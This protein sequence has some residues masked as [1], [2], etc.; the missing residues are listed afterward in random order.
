MTAIRSVA[1][2]V[3]LIVLLVGVP[4][5]VVG[6][7]DWAEVRLL[8]HD[9]SI[10]LLQDNG[11]VI[12]AILT[13]LG[14][15]FWVFLA[16]GIFLEVQDAIRVR[17]HG[18]TDKP[19]RG[20]LEWT[21]V[22]VRPL[23]S[24]AF[25]LAV[26][27]GG[28]H[29][30]AQEPTEPVPVMEPAWVGESTTSSQAEVAPRTTLADLDDGFYVVEPGD[31]LWSIAEKVYSNGQEWSRIAH[32]NEDLVEGTG[33]L[34]HVGWKLKIPPLSATDTV[35]PG[36]AVVVGPGDSLWSIADRNLGDGN[37]WPDIVR[38]N[39]GLV[40]DADLIQPGWE[41]TLPVEQPGPDD[42]G[43]TSAVSQGNDEGTTAL[44][45]V[46]AVPQKALGT[47]N[48]HSTRGHPAS[49]AST[50][51]GV[52]GVPDVAPGP[53]QEPTGDELTPPAADI[54]PQ[55]E[56]TPTDHSPQ[57]DSTNPSARPSP[58]DPSA[59]PSPTDSAAPTT[60]AAASAAPGSPESSSA[61][62]PSEPVSASP[63]SPSPDAGPSP[64][65]NSDHHTQQSSTIATIGMSTVLAGG[66]VLLVGRRRLTQLRA[67][68]L[69]RRILL[70]GQEGT[71]LETAMGIAGSRTIAEKPLVSAS[72]ECEETPPDPAA[73]AIAMNL[74]W[75]SETGITICLG[76]DQ[77]A[78]PVRAEVSGP[79]P[80]IVRAP[81]PDGLVPVMR[82]IAMSLA[83]DEFSAGRDLHVVDS[84]DLFDTF[85]DLNRHITYDQG[86]D[87]LQSMIADRRRFIGD[88]DWRRLS[89]D[90]NGAEAWRPAIFFF[91]EPVSDPQFDELSDCLKGRDIGVAVLISRNS[92]NPLDSRNL[93]SGHLDLDS[94]D[95]GIL[96]P[97]N[98]SVHPF[99]L[100]PSEPLTDLLRTSSSEDTTPAWWSVRGNTQSPPPQ[101]VSPTYSD[102]RGLDMISIAPSQTDAEAITFSHPVLK[103]LGPVCLE[104]TQGAAPIRAERSCMEYC[105][106][107]LEHPGTTATAMAQGLLVAEGTRR[108]NMSRL[109]G[110]LG[111]DTKGN[112]YLPE[113]YSGRIWLDTAV[114]SDWHRLRVLI[115]GGIESVGTDKLIQALRL[116]RGAPL[117]DV[118]PGQWHWAE[119]LRTDMVS[120]IR[121]IGVVATMGSLAVGNIDQARWAAS[122]A[123][124]AA[125]EDEQLLCARAR[126]EHLAG[127]RTE[128]ER[129]V[130]WITRNA[131]NL[132]T[133]LLPN[134]LVVLEEVMGSRLRS[135]DQPP[136]PLPPPTDV[137]PDTGEPT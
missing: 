29:S 89:T 114:T 113:A 121:D 79:T 95:H 123:L 11:H 44:D 87:T 122:H 23:V 43:S 135:P 37:L 28:S 112:P 17:S 68:P 84:S 93:P 134:T 72:N 107:L 45:S 92:A 3:A 125:P 12:L 71:L 59:Q 20:A 129:L 2:W 56:P 127:N 24:A 128:V 115:A 80:F 46:E 126:T 131:R 77:F 130:S 19:Q 35:T 124:N 21:R 48:S 73:D 22:L 49:G 39:Q 38:A 32:E 106:W 110:W 65:Q 25:A 97:D 69:G 108:S 55:S 102:E 90:P 34:I 9:P 67:R 4:W 75:L 94:V 52:V 120:V 91:V 60:A 109:R 61:P 54:T 116:V 16:G 7:G 86:R 26:L 30:A 105:G 78:Q 81:S 137:P 5:V 15:V 103:M 62:D 66:I 70:P 118:A 36:H 100:Q 101:I 58:T 40:R 57:P 74:K 18:R 76:E 132:G 98:I 104:G 64:T 88:D 33:N 27:G 13:V 133:D 63:P 10:F 85:T 14:A 83:L 8:I 31:S 111:A 41:L 47:A 99:Q 136:T 42:P 1:A 6:W 50:Q 51:T 119:E 117:V 96:H 53:D 82:G